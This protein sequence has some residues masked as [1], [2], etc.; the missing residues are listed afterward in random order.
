[1]PNG[2]G[3]AF[4]EFATVDTIVFDK[5]GTLTTASFEVSDVETYGSSSSSSS[6]GSTTAWEALLWRICQVVE[7]ASTHPISLGVRDYCNVR[8]AKIPEHA[9]VVELVGSQ[10]IPG[11]GLVGMVNIGGGET[12]R[13]LVGNEKLMEESGADYPSDASRSAAR[14]TLPG[15]QHE[16]KSVVLVAFQLQASGAPRN[17]ALDP[18]LNADRP[19]I[20]ALFAVRDPPRPE[21]ALVIATLKKQ[22]IVPW[23]ISGDNVTTA[24]TVAGMVGVDRDCVVAGASPVEKRDQVEYLQRHPSP[25]RRVGRRRSWFGFGFG[26][27]SET[28]AATPRS[29]VAF[30]GDGVNDAAAIA[31]AD[32]GLAMGGGSNI[33]LS[34]ADFA[35]L[36]SSLLAILTLRDL[37]RATIRKIYVSRVL[38]GSPSLRP[39]Y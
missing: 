21:A 26:K 7:Q 9:P 29:I 31:Q 36:G 33:A 15:W 18:S 19:T 37:S 24:R 4:Q 8:L 32:V 2:G 20:L 38:C 10:E 23:I 13:V 1:L 35:L 3:E 17:T 22:G 6:E 27:K 28:G 25:A 30:V 12:L 14:S 5:T 34:S 11:R 16:G 39:A